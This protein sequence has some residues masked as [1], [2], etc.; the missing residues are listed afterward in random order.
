MEA[1][2]EKTFWHILHDPANAGFSLRY[3]KTDGQAGRK[4]NLGKS[5][6]RFQGQSTKGKLRFDLIEKGAVL[7]EDIDG[8]GKPFTLRNRLISHIQLRG[9]NKWLRII[10]KNY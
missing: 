7:L 6:K 4:H 3:R 9:T 5:G 8:L 1:I 2:T 10:H